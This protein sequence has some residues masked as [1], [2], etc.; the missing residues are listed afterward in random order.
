M[1]STRYLIKRVSH[2]VLVVFGSLTLIFLLRHLTPGSPV[3][4][5]VPI[6]APPSV[7]KEVTRALGLH[8]PLYLQYIDY[9]TDVLSGD[10]G[11]SYIMQISVEQLII[12]RIPATVELALSAS[13][14]AIVLSLPLG[15][16]SAIRRNQPADYAATTFSLLGI[17][18]PNFWL[19]IM[20]VLL[21]SVQFNFLPT[22]GRPIAFV[23]AFSMLLFQLDPSGLITWTKHMILPAVTLGTYFTALITRVTRSEMLEELGQDYVRVC[24]AKGIPN[25]LVTF[26]HALRN[27]LIPVV[28]VTGLQLGYLING[29]VVTETIFN[30][31]GMGLLLIN[32]ING[33][34]WMVI[35]GIL[36]FVA[37]GWVTMNLVVDLLYGV[38]DPR[39]GL[40]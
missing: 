5:I 40:E 38:L 18:T 20:L 6:D 16:V 34:D 12:T 3:N 36:I 8:Q 7:R 14:I 28:T 26:K 17:S 37:I 19:G 30:W 39:V 11:H 27:S 4:V 31:P 24:R 10:F 9:M 29:S 15:V 35:Q 32:A 2:G 25:T 22:S 33:R 21:L 1:V 23:T 13:I